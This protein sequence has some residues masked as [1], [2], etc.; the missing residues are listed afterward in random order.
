MIL[1]MIWIY[2]NG[3][4]TV[5]M[6]KK[7]KTWEAF[8]AEFKPIAD[9]WIIYTIDDNNVVEIHYNDL[10]W[11]IHKDMKDLFGTEIEVREMNLGDYTHVSP[12][13]GWH[14]DWFEPEYKEIEFISKEEFEI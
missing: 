7:L 6:K 8:E 9:R 2:D 5:I 4:Y 3:V 14:E 11:Y 12:R 1:I 10:H 13:F